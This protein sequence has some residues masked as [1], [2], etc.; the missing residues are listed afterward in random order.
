[1][2]EVLTSNPEVLSLKG[3]HLYHFSISSCSQ[4]VRFAL[5]EK[6]IA[7]ESH[8]IDLNLMENVTPEYQAI[9]PKGYVPALVHDGKLIIESVDIISYI[10]QTFVGYKLHSEN[11]AENNDMHKWIGLSNNNQWCLKL[12]TYE[13]LFK[14]HGHFSKQEQ[15]DHYLTHQKNQELRQFT[16]DFVAG[17]SKERISTNIQQAYDF[18]KALNDGL[19]GKDYLSGNQFSLADIAAIVNVHRFKLCELNVEQYSELNRW[20]KTIEARPGFQKGIV[21][22]QPIKPS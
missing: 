11:D 1:M 12:L 22:W 8:P 18:M 19:K 4:R 6:G 9:H 14:K 13:I 17:F 20:Y 10:D 16:K 5:E 21:A 2:A 7:W 15:I 3:V